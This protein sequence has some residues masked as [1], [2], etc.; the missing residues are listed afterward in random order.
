MSGLMGK[1]VKVWSN[2]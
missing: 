1:Y 2:S